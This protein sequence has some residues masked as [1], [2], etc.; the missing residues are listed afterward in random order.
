MIGFLNEN[1]DLSAGLCA[2]PEAAED[3]AQIAINPEQGIKYRSNANA[4]IRHRANIARERF[5]RWVAED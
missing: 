4:A 2:F 1:S 5:L 3:C